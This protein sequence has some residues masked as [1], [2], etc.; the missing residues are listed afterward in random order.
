MLPRELGGVVDTELL[1]YGTRNLRV[2]DVGVVPLHAACHLQSNYLTIEFPLSHIHSFVLKLL[3]MRWAKQVRVFDKTS[4]S[5]S[6][7]S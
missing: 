2:V 3:H 5:C 7:S 1:V 4:M 6:Q